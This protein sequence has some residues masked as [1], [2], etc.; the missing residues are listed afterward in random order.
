AGIVREGVL[1]E[2]RQVYR[3]QQA[4]AVGRQWLFAAGIGRTDVLREPVVVHLVDLVDQDEAWLGEVVGGA[5]DDVPHAAR[6]QRP[7]NLAGTETFRVAHVVVRPRPFAP[8]ELLLVAYVQ[9]VLLGFA[10][11]HRE[12]EMPV[13]IR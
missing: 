9:P 5:H 7:V 12:G 6:G 11:R 1:H 8:H 4:G 2:A 10:R 13:G 3:S